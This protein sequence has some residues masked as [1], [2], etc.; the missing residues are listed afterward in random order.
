MLKT[1]KRGLSLIL[2]MVM[3]IAVVLSTFTM[4]ASAQTPTINAGNKVHTACFT[5]NIRA[6]ATAAANSLETVSKA[7]NRVSESMTSA[8]YTY[9]TSGWMSIKTSA[10]RDGHVRRDLVCPS[11]RCYKV[12]TS[13]GLRVR[14]TSDPT[15]SVL[16]TAPNGT[17][18]Q[19]M[20]VVSGMSYVRVRTGSEEGLI[21]FVVN[22]YIT[23][24][25]SSTEAD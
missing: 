20:D 6:G 2:S 9:S 12:N 18:L 13:A 15:S 17:Y 7:K 23:R 5:Y 21:G 14:S 16:Y 19:V 22:D 3:L 4:T 8:N 24:V 11:D 10:G 25:N 1:K